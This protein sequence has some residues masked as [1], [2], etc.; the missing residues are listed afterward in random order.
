MGPVST[1]RQEL[2]LCCCQQSFYAADST[3]NQQCDETVFCTCCAFL[4]RG[5]H[6]ETRA[7][8]KRKTFWRSATRP[9]NWDAF[10]GWLRSDP[11]LGCNWMCRTVHWY[12]KSRVVRMFPTKIDIQIG[13]PSIPIPRFHGKISFCWGLKTPKKNCQVKSAIPPLDW[14]RCYAVVVKQRRHC[15]NLGHFL[16]LWWFFQVYFSQN[17]RKHVQ[18]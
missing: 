14:P 10:Y 16:G 11:R 1:L 7:T 8:R 2:F 6:R 3:G 9:K 17:F 4:E 13:Y 12:P 18:A 15:G 5:F